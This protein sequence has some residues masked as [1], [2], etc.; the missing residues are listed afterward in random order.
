MTVAYVTLGL[1][2]LIIFMGLCLKILEIL[3]KKCTRCGG[4]MVE[5]E[6]DAN[7][8]ADFYVCPNCGNRS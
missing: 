4:V 7:V 3:P 5:E 2:L 1:I 8:P 6:F